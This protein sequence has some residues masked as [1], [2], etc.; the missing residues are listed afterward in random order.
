MSQRPFP[1]AAGLARRRRVRVIHCETE[2]VLLVPP[3]Q[4]TGAQT[5]NRTAQFS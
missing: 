1:F 5:A 3:Y 2:E 4:H